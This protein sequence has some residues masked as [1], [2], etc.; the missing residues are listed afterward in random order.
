MPDFNKPERVLWSLAVAV[1]LVILIGF[2]HGWRQ[3]VPLSPAAASGSASALV[4]SLSHLL[5]PRRDSIRV[6]L[7]LLS[8]T[9]AMIA[10]L[11]LFTAKG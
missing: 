2:L 10:A 9:F 6:G 11:A 3:G 4:L 5:H 1:T 8:L 7:A